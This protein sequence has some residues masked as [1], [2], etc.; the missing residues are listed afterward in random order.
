M[1]IMP[2]IPQPRH[3]GERFGGRV[4]IVTLGDGPP[5]SEYREVGHLRFLEA[6]LDLT[7]CVDQLEI[8]EAIDIALKNAQDTVQ[9][10]ALRLR[11]TSARHSAEELQ[12]L[13]KELLD[14][15]D[16]V[17]LDKVKT[18]MPKMPTDGSPDDLVR[19]MRE[20]FQ[21]AGFQKASAQI[22]DDLRVAL[23][24]SVRDTL[25]ETELD[26]LLTDAINEV[27]VS[28]HGEDLQ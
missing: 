13:A 1:A 4:A 21:E 20:E 28:L 3:F 2:G 22:I 26:E 6:E 12:T 25:S 23:P 19:L 9:D 27:S 7:D 17:F 10:T 5:E 24:A 18:Q 15:I 11:V 16:R 14:D 8:L